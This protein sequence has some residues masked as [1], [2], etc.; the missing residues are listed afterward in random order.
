[1]T[2]TEQQT[3]DTLTN[4]AAEL[5]SAANRVLLTG[6]TPGQAAYETL[7]SHLEPSFD[8]SQAWPFQDPRYRAAWEAAANAAINAAPD[9]RNE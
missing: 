9:D 1:M 2:Q 8:A 5:I 7:Y 3:A 6:K 4:R